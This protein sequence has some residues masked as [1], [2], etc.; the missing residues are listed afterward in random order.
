[1]VH[2]C[3]LWFCVAVHSF[4]ERRAGSHGKS[5]QSRESSRPRSDPVMGCMHNILFLVCFLQSEEIT[6]PGTNAFKYHLSWKDL[7]IDSQTEPTSL[8]LILKGSKT[9]PFRGGVKVI[10]GQTGDELCPVA[11]MMA[12]AVVRGHN[13]GLL[14]KHRARDGRLLWLVRLEKPWV[15]T[16][17]LCKP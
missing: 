17:R 16:T 9:D 11:S 10:I 5:S 1:M 4:W 7:A 2:L 8:Q 14:F 13:P 6:I 12:Y 15:P 3:C